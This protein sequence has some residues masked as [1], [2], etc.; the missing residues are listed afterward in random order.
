MFAAVY[1]KSCK[2][3]AAFAAMIAGSLTRFIFEFALMKDSLLLAVGTYAD[4]FAA[5]LYEYADFKKFTNWDI[6][7]A[8][9][10]A[11]DYAA[12]GQQ[13]VCPQRPLNDWTGL[14]S[15]LSPCVCMLV[16]LIGQ[17]VLPNS[18][19]PWFTPVEGEE[20]EVKKEESS[21]A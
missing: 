4:T 6:L 18:D 14:D 8:A 11:V 17:V 10:G 12:N 9:Q 2:P 15:L 5:G 1:W 13:E 21:V 20:A 16:L 19:H 7:V 3:T